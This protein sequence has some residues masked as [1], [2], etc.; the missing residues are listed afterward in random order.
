MTR[1][2]PPTH[3]RQAFGV[4]AAPGRELSIPYYKKKAWPGRVFSRLVETTSDP[5]AYQH[6]AIA[7][8]EYVL[9]ITKLFLLFKSRHGENDWIEP[10]NRHTH[11]K[12]LFDRYD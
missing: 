2:S 7:C 8:G 9:K 6:A 12:R 10:S 4:G 5:R 1:S 3:A 11:A